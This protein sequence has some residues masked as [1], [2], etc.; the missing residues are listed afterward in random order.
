MSPLICAPQLT[1]CAATK[2]LGPLTGESPATSRSRNGRLKNDLLVEAPRP[3]V[4][5]E[6]HFEFGDGGEVGPGTSV[7]DGHHRRGVHAHVSGGGADTPVSDGGL[8]VQGELSGDLSDWVY[9]GHFGPTVR[10][11]SRGESGG[12]GHGSSVEHTGRPVA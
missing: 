4:D 11:V 9:R 1:A 3:K 6:A 2:H 12:P 8:N 7:K 5:A 10:E